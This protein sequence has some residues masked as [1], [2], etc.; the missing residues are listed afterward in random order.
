VLGCLAAAFAAGTIIYL[1]VA[2]PERAGAWRAAVWMFVAGAAL[3]A[4]GALSRHVMRS[5]DAEDM[6]AWSFER[7]QAMAELSPAAATALIAVAVS[8][9]LALPFLS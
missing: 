8:L 9:L 2:G 4:L 1:A 7:F 5:E 3:L 6:S